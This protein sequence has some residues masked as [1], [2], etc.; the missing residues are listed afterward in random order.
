MILLLYQ[1][2]NR[3]ISV[4]LLRFLRSTGSADIA[5]ACTSIAAFL[6]IFV[7]S[8]ERETFGQ[9][10]PRDWVAAVPVYKKWANASRGCQNAFPW[11]A[12]PS[13]K[14]WMNPWI[15]LIFLVNVCV[16]VGATIW[17]DHNDSIDR[18]QADTDVSIVSCHA[19]WFCSLQVAL[20]FFCNIWDS[21]K[22]GHNPNSVR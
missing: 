13:N 2:R 6:S 20:I 4:W 16:W 8:E 5:E 9:N 11:P 17:Q 19:A 1:L 22:N 14:Y 10:R 12:W 21:S 7:W 3:Q 15:S 18:R